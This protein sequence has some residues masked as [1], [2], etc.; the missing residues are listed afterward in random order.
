MTFFIFIIRQGKST[1]VCDNDIALLSARFFPF[2]A[3]AAVK[4]TILLNYLNRDFDDAD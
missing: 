1:K 3:L 4:N 2:T